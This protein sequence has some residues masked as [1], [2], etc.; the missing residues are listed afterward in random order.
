MYLQSSLSAE[1]DLLDDS[2][3]EKEVF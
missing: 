3:A 2:D 1:I